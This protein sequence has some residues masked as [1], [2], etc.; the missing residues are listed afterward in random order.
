MDFDTF[1]ERAWQEHAD[2]AA[3]IAARLLAEGPALVS[4]DAQLARL[5]PL[6]HHV[7]GEH[8]ARWAEGQAALEALATLPPI[9]PQGDGAKAVRRCVASL[10]LS[11]GEADALAGLNPGDAVRVRALSAGNLGE[12]D[13]S[14]AAEL[15]EAAITAHE[16]AA[17]P[18]ADPATRSLAATGWNIACALEAKTERSAAERALMIRAAQISRV[19]WERAGTWLE[20]ERG[21]Y[22]LAITWLLAGEPARARRHAQS[23]LDIVSANAG[24]PLERFFA[25]ESLGRVARTLG[26]AAG[27]AQ[28]LDQAR[29][30]FDTLPEADRGWVQPS[31]TALAAAPADKKP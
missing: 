19:Y 3:G 24:P 20:V 14:R 22:R 30:A 25:W 8:L 27:Y 16:A 15:L 9:T 4:S 26:D 31:L 29:Q 1:M 5:V 7:Y 12:R 28:A 18:A 10:R 17:L 23:C 6:V 21:E 11:A 2:D 13:A